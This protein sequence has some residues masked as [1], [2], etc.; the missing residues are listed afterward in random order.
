MQQKDYKKIAEMIKNNLTADR[1]RIDIEF[2]NELTDYFDEYSKDKDDE[3]VN[4]TQAKE[5]RFNKKQFLK[6]CGVE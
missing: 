2:V 1:S 5:Y 6:D 4:E 3:W